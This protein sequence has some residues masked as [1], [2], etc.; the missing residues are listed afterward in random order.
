MCTVVEV[1]TVAP[2]GRGAVASVYY[3]GKKAVFPVHMDTSP[4]QS[5]WALEPGSI[6]YSCPAVIVQEK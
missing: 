3:T 4:S 5:F 2:T 6:A 1:F